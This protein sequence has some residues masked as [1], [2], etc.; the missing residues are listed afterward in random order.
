VAVDVSGLPGLRVPRCQWI[1]WSSIE[2]F[3]LT[4]KLELM[5]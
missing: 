4:I 1:V 2:D 5:Y 3:L